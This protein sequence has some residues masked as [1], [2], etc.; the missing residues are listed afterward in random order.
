M[1]E[2]AIEIPKNADLGGDNTLSKGENV[3]DI[4]LKMVT[5]D[6]LKE[7]ISLDVVTPEMY[8][9]TFKT[10]LKLFDSSLELDHLK[11]D[12][13]SQNLETISKIQEENRE[14]SQKIVKNIELA[15]DAI[16][17]EN[18]E[19]L[20]EVKEHMRELQ[21]KIAK[22][23]NEIYIDTLTKVYNRKW[24]FDKEL[25][26]DTFK[27]SGVMT[28]IDLDSFKSINDTYGH[29]AGDKVLLLVANMLVK[30]EGCEILRYGGDEFILISY[31][32]NK[33]EIE[34]DLHLLNESFTNK[35]LKFQGKTFKISLS[36]GSSTFHEGD[37][38]K[39]VAQAVDEKMY[40][41]KR[42]K[43][44]TNEVASLSH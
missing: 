35:S 10:K 36:F 13:I 38:F 15:Q 23:E 27:E 28:F 17:Q 9:A 11:V 4:D 43:K 8:E 41:Q 42:E 19:V 30:I 12:I 33:T 2:V 16:E 22:L 1:T 3:N 32:R 25:E 29:L 20:Q 39:E 44:A 37:T 26:N 5:G 21:N 31:L 24:L 6:T 18:R 14:N 7:L 34:H 40:A